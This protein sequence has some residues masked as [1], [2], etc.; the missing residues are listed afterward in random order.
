[1]APWAEQCDPSGRGELS[2]PR[3]KG[4]LR[5][6]I[7]PNKYWYNGKYYDAKADEPTIGHTK[8][9]VADHWESTG[10]NCPQDKR[11][12]FFNGDGNCAANLSIQPRSVNCSD[13]GGTYKD[14]VGIN[15]RGP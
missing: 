13:N 4:G 1:M 7:D 15:F 8:M 2:T 9:A 12:D 10:S 14:K 3:A 11:K 6:P 5:H